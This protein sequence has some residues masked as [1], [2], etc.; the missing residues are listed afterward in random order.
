MELARRGHRVDLYDRGS[1]PV[2]QASF[3]NEGKIH[4]GLVYANDPTGRTHETMLR[5]AL[6]FVPY[7]AR[8]LDG[9]VMLESEPFDYA[10]HRTSLLSVE[11]VAAHFSRV[12]ACYDAMSEGLGLR[13]PGI[14]KRPFVVPMTG[15]ERSARFDPELVPMAYRTGERFA[16]PR[17]LAIRLRA[18]IA[19]EPRIAFIGDTHVTGIKPGDDGRI[20][21]ESEREGEGFFARYGQVV[22]AL[23][24]GRLK[25]DRSA[26]VAYRRSWLYRTK[27]GLVLPARIDT[28]P[29]PSVT[30][31]LGSYGDTV[32][33]D[34]GML[35][36]SWYPDCMIGSS[37]ELVSPDFIARLDAEAR[38]AIAEASLAA[39]STLV[40][41]LKAY[42]TQL[43]NATVG[44]G[45][46]A[47]WGDAG[48]E[49][50]ASELHRRYDIGVSSYGRYH[51]VDTGKY[52]MAPLF[53]VEACDR[54]EGAV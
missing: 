8:W 26:D 44:G 10:V 35:Y 12:E 9:P 20:G 19:A 16:N 17:L 14:D 43:G 41:S 21:V 23:W 18:A 15:R 36:L 29:V 54:I 5:G 50:P 40:P 1:E 25:I 39:L 46:I 47:A 6:H 49:D 13:Y 53:A 30:F 32:R 38:A 48:I 27:L 3:W 33:Y 52:T 24:A 37:S 28:P 45:V 31:V 22:N 2:T 42:G 51:S 11:R 34:D 4:L 7:L